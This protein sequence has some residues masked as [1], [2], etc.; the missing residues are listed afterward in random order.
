[1]GSG[2][3]PSADLRA[4][5]HDPERGHAL[6]DY[7][8]PPRCP[9]KRQDR[10]TLYICCRWGLATVLQALHHKPTRRLER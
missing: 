9:V 2:R 3:P 10:Y 7:L 5:N 8:P 4:P 1:M 6:G